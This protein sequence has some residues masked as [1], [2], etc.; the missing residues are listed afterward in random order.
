MKNGLIILMLICFLAFPISKQ[1]DASE[2]QPS[3]EKWPTKDLTMVVNF[4]AGGGL[5]ISARLLAKYWEKE[6]GVGIKVENR[7]GASGQV[8]TTYFMSLPDDG[9]N[10]LMGAQIYYSSNIV[11][12]GATYTIDDISILNYIEMDPCSLVVTP[13]SPFQSFESL[14]TAIK[15]NPG[16]FKMGLASGGVSTIMIEYLKKHFDWDIKI[17]NYDSNAQRMAAL[18]GG[19][20]DFATTALMSGIDR[21]KSLLVW[22]DKRYAFLPDVPTLHEIIKEKVPYVTNARFIALHSSV[23]EKY[24]DRYQILLNTL[25]KAYKN[26]EYQKALQDSKRDKISMWLGPEESDR[27]N[28]EFHETVLEYKSALS[29]L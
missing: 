12:Q 10:V 27:L 14:N 17:V 29:G 25:E 7:A 18:L 1:A 23:K 24:P 3:A 11:I 22:A 16:K 4:G 5:D 20:I 6:L 15:A 13:K 19:H 21:E 9:T 28:R 26:P 2:N 8:G